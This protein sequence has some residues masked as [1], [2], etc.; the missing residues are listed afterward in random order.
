MAAHGGFLK[1]QRREGEMIVIEDEMSIFFFFG[2]LHFFVVDENKTN[3]RGE[4]L[5][6][7]NQ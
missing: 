7:S 3:C 1:G 2:N 4:V 5:K 6:A